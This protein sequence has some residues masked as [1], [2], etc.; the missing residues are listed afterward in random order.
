MTYRR[1]LPVLATLFL[2]SY[3]GVLRTVL[4]VFFSYST[5]THLPSGHQQLVWSI[6]A[7]VPLFG[8]KFT[9]LFITCLVLFLV[10]IPF[11]ITLLF[12]RYLMNF[13][14]VNQF[15]P[16]LDAF[17]GSYK[18]K[19]YYWLAVHLIL[20][21]LFFTFYAFPTN[22]NLIC[23]TML[24][25]AFSVYSGYVRPNK[26]KSVNIQELLLLINL[27][28]MYAVSFQDN[29]F[30]IVANTMISLA[31]VQ[32]AI[33]ISYHFLTYT[34]HCDIVHMER[35]VKEKVMKLCK[36]KPLS[37]VSNNIALLNIPE[38]TYNY[39]EYRDGLVSDDFR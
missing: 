11:N 8:L 3:T 20:R 19:Y 39:T 25:I 28:I 29:T 30:F 9:I 16:I 33:I 18:E 36:K 26:M 35:I 31:F 1:S 13:R 37:H 10:L 22:I 32:F 38:C 17:Q 15:K 6:D 2:L 27:T 7:S 4:T 24:L 34:C 12:T 23:S 21:S 14:I 5:I